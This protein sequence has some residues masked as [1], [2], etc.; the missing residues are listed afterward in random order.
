MVNSEIL[1]TILIVILPALITG[2]IGSGFLTSDYFKKSNEPI[3]VIDLDLPKL[4][5]EATLKINNFGKSPAT[6]FT[7][8]FSSPQNIKEITNKLSV[9][10]ITITTKNNVIREAIPIEGQKE[11][12]NNFFELHI[13]KLIH[14]GITLVFLNIKFDSVENLTQDNVKV[15]SKYDQGS[16]EGFINDKIINL[17]VLFNPTYLYNLQYK[18]PFLFYVIIFLFLF[19]IIEYVSVSIILLKRWKNNRLTIF[20]Y[21]LF[22]LR[23]I[24]KEMYNSGDYNFEKIDNKIYKEILSPKWKG[25]K[26]YPVEFYLFKNNYKVYRLMFD[27]RF[28][29]RKNTNNI[30]QEHTII[31][32]IALID[33]LIT[34]LKESKQ[35]S[36]KGDITKKK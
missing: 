12:N 23:E 14:G 30:P 36:L 6:N 24:L 11:I 31:E 35:F 29:L 1:N 32:S 19:I 15:I 25:Y 3:I 4:N 26:K 17:I 10:N 28:N 21:N 33:D 27:L 7:L 22:K 18:E 34:E 20:I 5:N 13:P 16:A 9:E 8:F 2:F